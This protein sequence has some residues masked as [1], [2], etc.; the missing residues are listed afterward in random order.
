[1]T[2]TGFYGGKTDR[3]EGSESC[4]QMTESGGQRQLA[5]RERNLL[6]W[7]LYLFL[8]DPEGAAWETVLLSSLP[9][10]THHLFNLHTVATAV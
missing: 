6:S 9:R 5:H 1:M 10:E 8:R 4:P 7:L 2:F 3:V